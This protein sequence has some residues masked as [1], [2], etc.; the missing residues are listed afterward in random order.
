MKA[1]L[2]LKPKG[3]IPITG[4]PKQRW[5]VDRPSRKEPSGNLNGET[6]SSTG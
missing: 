1:V 2:K 5:I 6:V 3:K 4:I